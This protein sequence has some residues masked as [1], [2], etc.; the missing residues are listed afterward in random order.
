MHPMILVFAAL[1]ASSGGGET[2][3]P[4][5]SAGPVTWIVLRYRGPADEQGPPVLLYLNDRALREGLAFLKRERNERSA[6]LPADD[7]EAIAAEISRAHSR[8]NGDDAVT[9]AHFQFV[10]GSAD[11]EPRALDFRRDAAAPLVRSVSKRTLPDRAR[12]VL[13]DFADEH[14][15]KAGS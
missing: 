1:A 15:L 6:E 12:E 2:P 4:D 10:L 8:P 9:A 5:P 11:G 14:G 7:L 13:D 3:G